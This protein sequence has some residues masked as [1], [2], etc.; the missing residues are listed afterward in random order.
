MWISFWWIGGP[1]IL[2]ANWSHWDNWWNDTDYSAGRPWR[3]SRWSR[4]AKNILEKLLESRKITETIS[5]FGLLVSP[6]WFANRVEEDARFVREYST[7]V[8]Q[9]ESWNIHPKWKGRHHFEIEFRCASGNLENLERALKWI[10]K[11]H[12]CSW[13]KQ[14]HSKADCPALR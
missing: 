5:S 8:I 13:L 9:A 12:S 6:K 7:K 14:I 3:W 2:S 4:G 10:A 1:G 11:V